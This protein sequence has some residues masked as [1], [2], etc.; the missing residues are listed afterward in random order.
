MG[1]IRDKLKEMGLSETDA[2][3]LA[4]CIVT[5]KSCSWVNTDEIDNAAL[6]RLGDYLK[7]NGHKLRVSVEPVSTRN[8]YIWEVKAFQ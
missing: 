4:D 6:Q 5:K 7:E 1:E 2:E 8:K 3:A